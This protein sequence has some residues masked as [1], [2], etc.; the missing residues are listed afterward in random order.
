MI[1][2]RQ[3]LQYAAANNVGM[4]AIMSVKSEEHYYFAQADKEVMVNNEHNIP[5]FCVSGLEND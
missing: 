4:I 5:V 2:T 3:T 1:L